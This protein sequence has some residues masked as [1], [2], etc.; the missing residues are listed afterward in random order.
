MRHF[1]LP[2][3]A[4]LATASTLV[5]APAPATAATSYD[6]GL[7]VPFE[8][9]DAVSGA[10]VSVLQYGATSGNSADDDAVAIQR[11]INAAKPGDMVYIP[12]GTYHVKSMI[13]LKSGVSVVGQS[14]PRRQQSDLVEL[15]TGSGVGQTVSGRNPAG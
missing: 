8:S 7:T 10:T 13:M 4:L 12:D 1:A 15:P 3:A 6:S 2:V 14:R 9:P 5:A 11:A